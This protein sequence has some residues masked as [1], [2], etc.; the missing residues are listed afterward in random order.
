MKKYEAILYGWRNTE[1]GKMYIGYHKTT[2]V[3]DGYIFSTE[4]EEAH[5]A[6]SYG[7]LERTIIHRGKQSICITLEN[8]I[9]KKEKAN[10]N[11]MFY[12]K[13]VG[14]GVGC[15]KDFSNLTKSVMKLAEDWVAGKVATRQTSNSHVDKEEIKTL[16]DDIRNGRYKTLNHERVSAIYALPRN[17]VRFNVVDNDHVSD[18]ADKM[19]DNPA[20]ARLNVSPV[21]VI[22]YPD[23]KKEVIDGNHTIHAA[24]EA[25]WV[26]VPVIYI[27]SSEFKGKQANIDYFGYCMNHQEKLKKPNDNQDLKRA[28][29]NFC[30]THNEYVLGTEDFKDAFKQAY[31]EF[32]TNKQIS[33]SMVSVKKMLETEEQIRKN[34]FKVY[35]HRELMNK[36]KQLETENPATAVISITSG[37]CF[38]AGIGAILNKAGGLDVWQGIMLI[39]HRNM[40]EYQTYKHSKAKLNAAMKRVDPKM[41]INIVELPSFV[42]TK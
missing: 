26:E 36:V 17:Q 27:N 1:N 20:K 29:V 34:N 10:K 12:N 31:G 18:I 6:W 30:N 14:G 24:D 42:N 33:Q 19:R 5:L 4:D 35:S 2:D 40:H 41:K 28:I 15:V 21:I 9:L 22:V 3:D 16:A 37:S 8:Y 32:W 13:S 23:G 7:K 25:G 11:P 38:N 39:T